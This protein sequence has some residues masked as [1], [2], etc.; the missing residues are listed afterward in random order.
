VLTDLKMNLQL[1]LTRSLSNGGDDRIERSIDYMVKHT[2]RPL[3]LS[4][5]AAM[6]D[7]SPSRYF[8][9]FKQRM[10]CTPMHYFTRLRMKHACRLLEST[11]ARVKEVAAVLGY[12][13]PLYFSRVFK[14]VHNLPPS[15]Y[16]AVGSSF[17]VVTENRLITH[18]AAQISS[19]V[20]VTRDSQMI[21]PRE[22]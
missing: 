7:M 8:E 6:V 12:H 19:E 10:G 14:S 20:N 2:D 3:Q 4:T 11:S 18:Q 5:L 9:L 21:P 13:D 15:R 22:C 1:Q 16:K 17:S